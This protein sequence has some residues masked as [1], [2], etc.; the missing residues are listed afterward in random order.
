MV[1]S[2]PDQADVDFRWLVADALVTTGKRSSTFPSEANMNR[3][4]R[5]CSPLPPFSVFGHGCD[6]Q[7][8]CSLCG[9]RRIFGAIFQ[10]RI[11]IDPMQAGSAMPLFRQTPRRTLNGELVVRLLPQD[12]CHCQR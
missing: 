1:M 11:I 2:Y 7:N 4:G 8:A 3:K 6:C 5:A 12:F 10:A 9:I